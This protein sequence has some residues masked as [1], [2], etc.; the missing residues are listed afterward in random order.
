MTAMTVVTKTS[1][2]EDA[3]HGR[4]DQIEIFSSLIPRKKTILRRP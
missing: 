1:F 3:K 4:R 2:V